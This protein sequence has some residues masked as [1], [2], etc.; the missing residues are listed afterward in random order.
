MLS[1][2][3]AIRLQRCLNV[4]LDRIP[5]LWPLKHFVAVNPFLGLVHQPFAEACES[6]HRATGSLPLP[7]ATEFRRMWIE[8]VIPP[9][10][11]D[12]VLDAEW[13]RERLVEALSPD[14]PSIPGPLPTFADLLDAHQA[15][16]HWG[17]L[18]VEEKIK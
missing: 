16:S 9:G 15:G 14:H 7:S 12:R 2:A 11:L 18:V 6:W 8:G 1:Q 3:E 4:A 5:P 10:D 17:S 13:T